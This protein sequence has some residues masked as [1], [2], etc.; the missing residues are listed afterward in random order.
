[1]NHF[2]FSSSFIFI[3]YYYCLIH[4]VNCAHW[5]RSFEFEQMELISIF[6]HFIKWFWIPNKYQIWREMLWMECV[7]NLLCS[8]SLQWRQHMKCITFV[9]LQRTLYIRSSI[10]SFWS[11]FIDLWCYIRFP[12]ECLF[13]FY[14]GWLSAFYFIPHTH[15]H[16]ISISI[17]PCACLFLWMSVFIYLFIYLFSFLV[18]L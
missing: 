2:F 7:T 5:K 10:Q 16:I 11:V 4:I 14:K 12:L 6:H 13:Y 9:L 18:T 17:T 15:T 1:M 8:S 3:Y